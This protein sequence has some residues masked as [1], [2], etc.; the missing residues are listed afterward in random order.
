MAGKLSQM[1]SFYKHWKWLTFSA[2]FCMLIGGALLFK[3]FTATAA[4][5][6]VIPT[7][8]TTC[9]ASYTVAAQEAFYTDD[10]TITN[11]GSKT[12]H[13][14]KVQI[15]FPGKQVILTGW[16]GVFSQKGNTVIIRNTSANAV[17]PPGSSINPGFNGSWNNTTPDPSSIKLNRVTCSLS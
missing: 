11:T 16:N 17:V 10:F 7:A 6:N 12:L 8:P 13:G 9:Q 3:P 4:S 1:R 14:W 15:V 2:L 5:A